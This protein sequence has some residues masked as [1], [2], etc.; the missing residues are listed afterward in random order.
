MA[1][2]QIIIRKGS[3]VCHSYQKPVLSHE[4]LIWICHCLCFSLRERYEQQILYSKKPHSATSM[5]QIMSV[6]I[7]V[8]N[9]SYSAVFSIVYSFRSFLYHILAISVM[10][11]TLSIRH[12]KKG[13]WNKIAQC[14]VRFTR[15]MKPHTTA[16][17]DIHSENFTRLTKLN[18]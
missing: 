4:Y 6:V 1:K 16:F 2:K 9:E 10:S 7:S 13:Q 17:R 18:C 12:A 15:E 8:V 5:H 11:S 3:N 14:F